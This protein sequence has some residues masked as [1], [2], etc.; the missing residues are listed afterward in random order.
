M[1]IKETILIASGDDS[2]INCLTEILS[3]TYKI[4]VSRNG[5]EAFD[6]L[7]SHFPDINLVIAAAQMQMIDGFELLRLMKISKLLNIVPVL[8]ITE[9]GVPE[10][11]DKAIE[12]GAEDIL[13]QPFDAKVVQKRTEGVLRSSRRP[14]YQ[15]VMEELVMEQIDKYI[16]KLGICHCLTCR[17]DLAALALNHLKPKYVNTEKGKLI[18]ATE[19]MSY[20]NILEIVGVIAECA[21]SVKMH[22]RHTGVY[23][24]K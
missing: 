24:G 9:H 21:E 15:N 2:E 16:D 7:N 22:P 23:M 8:I 14:T 13:D 19:K 10:E 5:K 4:V 3:D 20:D 17:C 11:M 1:K 6:Y 12:R 18:S